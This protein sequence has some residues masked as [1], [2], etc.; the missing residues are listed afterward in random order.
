[1]D[2]VR[3]ARSRSIRRFG[4]HHDGKTLEAACTERLHMRDIACVCLKLNLSGNVGF[5]CF[6]LKVNYPAPKGAG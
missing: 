4:N 2:D 1:M 6:D 5:K 3:Y